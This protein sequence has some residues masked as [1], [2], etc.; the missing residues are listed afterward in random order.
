MI[1]L[2]WQQSWRKC[3]KGKQDFTKKATTTHQW[4]NYRHFQKECK[5]A[6]RQAEIDYTNNVIQQGLEQNNTK[7]FWKL[8][9]SKKQDNVGVSPLFKDGKLESGSQGKA[10]I[11]L[12][13]FSSVF[14]QKIPGPMPPVRN[15]VHNSLTHI[16][17]DIKGTESLQHWN[18]QKLTSRRDRHLKRRYALIN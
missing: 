7:P 4:A 17:I 1:S 5:K 8:I 15:T 16:K 13:Q 10:E 6:F 11:L 3:V 14:T 12:Q 2:G 18:G 9:K